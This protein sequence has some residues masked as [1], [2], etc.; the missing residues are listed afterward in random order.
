MRGAHDR[1]S[2]FVQHAFRYA[3]ERLTGASG[4]E[5]NDRAL[6]AVVERAGAKCVAQLR[7]ELRIRAQRCIELAVDFAHHARARVFRDAF[8]QQ[9]LDLRFDRGN[10]AFDGGGVRSIEE[11][12]LRVVCGCS[13]GILPA[14]LSFNS[15]AAIISVGAVPL[16]RKM[17]KAKERCGDGCLFSTNVLRRFFGAG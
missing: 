9:P 3:G 6:V 13:A 12:E 16:L 4:E 14:I 5:R 11:G 7:G 15:V 8:G 17:L 2:P 1:R 10:D